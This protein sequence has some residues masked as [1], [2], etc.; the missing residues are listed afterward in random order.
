MCR[1]AL[2][3]QAIDISLGKYAAL[4]RDVMD[5]DPRV[6]EVAQLVGRNLQLGGSC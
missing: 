4:A 5:L 1:N 6:A 3:L 2:F